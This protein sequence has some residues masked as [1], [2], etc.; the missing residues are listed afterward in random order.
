[1]EQT[2]VVIPALQDA[3]ERILAYGAGHSPT[4][5]GARCHPE[6][7]SNQAAGTLEI[8]RAVIDFQRERIFAAID[9]DGELTVHQN[10]SQVG[11][12]VRTQ[13]VLKAS[14]ES[15]N[16][17]AGIAQALAGKVPHPPVVWTLQQGP[18][19]VARMNGEIILEAGTARDTHRTII[20]FPNGGILHS[21]DEAQR[22]MDEVHFPQ[23]P[24]ISLEP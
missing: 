23:Y 5:R 21:L 19:C 14:D 11:Q 9:P 12:P 18:W 24:S 22:L 6:Y 2:G 15:R 13:M 17:Y 16:A 20:T 8:T 1:M 7:R 4:V 3:A 10:W